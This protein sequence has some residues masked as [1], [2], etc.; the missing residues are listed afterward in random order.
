M[1]AYHD[2]GPKTFSYSRYDIIPL[3]DKSATKLLCQRF[4]AFLAH[5]GIVVCSSRDK[6]ASGP[7][8]PLKCGQQ[9]RNLLILFDDD[10]L[11]TEPGHIAHPMLKARC[12]CLENARLLLLADW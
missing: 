4:Q 3:L 5:W 2:G 1:R 8:A 12:V 11:H 6:N 7:Y 10:R 9:F